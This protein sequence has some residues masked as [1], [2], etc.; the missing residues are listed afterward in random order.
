[1]YSRRARRLGLGRAK[2]TYRE[3]LVSVLV[4]A[5]LE[6]K[7]KEMELRTDVASGIYRLSLASFIPFL[8]RT[9]AR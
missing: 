8:A 2:A 9:R 7:R 1:M 3:L 5:D 6:M 4:Y